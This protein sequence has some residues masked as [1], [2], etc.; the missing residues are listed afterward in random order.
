MSAGSADGLDGGLTPLPP[1]SH[2]TSCARGDGRWGKLHGD[3]GI[4]ELPLVALNF[5]PLRGLTA[6]R[7]T[8]ALRRL[9]QSALQNAKRKME[10]QRLKAEAER[11]RH[12]GLG[13]S[14]D[15]VPPGGPDAR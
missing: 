1:L 6:E 13:G 5:R 15:V 2:A 10:R 8:G 11:Q 3:A 4:H 9:M 7:R 12:Y 14:G